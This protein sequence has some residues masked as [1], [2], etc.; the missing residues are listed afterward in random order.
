MKGTADQV[1]S[2]PTED[3]PKMKKNGKKT[4]DFPDQTSG[5]FHQKTRNLN[6]PKLTICS[7]DTNADFI[8]IPQCSIVNFTIDIFEHL[9]GNS[10]PPG[11]T[12]G[13]S[14]ILFPKILCEFIGCLIRHLADGIRHNRLRGRHN[15]LI[16]PR[17]SASRDHEPGA[18]RFLYLIRGHRKHCDPCSCSGFDDIRGRI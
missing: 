4:K 3:Q 8:I 15:I 16:D 1:G 5:F 18:F 2:Q 11:C 14:R 10:F 12:V 17:I 13:H 7:R 6:E 9:R